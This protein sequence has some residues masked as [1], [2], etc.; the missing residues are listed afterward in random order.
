M[1]LAGLC[2]T[3]THRRQFDPNYRNPFSNLLII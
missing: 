3:Y 2:V 1:R